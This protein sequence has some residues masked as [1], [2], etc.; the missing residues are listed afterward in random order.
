M[1]KVHRA[2]KGE[3]VTD[4]SETFR[5]LFALCFQVYNEYSGIEKA[6]D[7]NSTRRQ[8]GIDWSSPDDG[9]PSRH[10]A[11]LTR[12]PVDIYRAILYKK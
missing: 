2:A 4:S 7:N 11:C 3:C 5:T 10:F 12:C 8:K 9:F 1:N 6:T